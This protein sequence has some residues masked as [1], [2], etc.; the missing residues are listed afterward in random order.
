MNAYNAA[1]FTRFAGNLK[2]EDGKR[3][4]LKKF[5]KDILR[6]HF[7]Q[8]RELVV[9]IPKKNG[10][11][12]LLAALALFHLT[13]RDRA[14]VIIVAASRDQ[15]KV[16]F[17]Q[18]VML[19]ESTG[20]RVKGTGFRGSDAPHTWNLFGLQ[21]DIRKGYREIRANDGRIKV[22]S[23][24]ADT[25]DGQIPTLALVDEL[26]RHRDGQL[27]D[28]LMRG[29]GPRQGRMVT[30]S[31]AGSTEESALGKL[32]QKAH[33]LRSRKITARHKRYAKGE[34]VLHELALEAS[35]DPNDLKTVK[36]V[37]PLQPMSELRRMQDSASNTIGQW[38]RFTC[39]IWTAGD[40]PEILPQDWDRLRADIGVVEPGDR[41]VLAPSAGG[42]AVVGIA[43]MRPDG[44]VAVKAEHLDAPQGRSILAL[45]ENK[46]IELC[47]VYDVEIVLGPRYGLTRAMELV[48][49]RGAPVEEHPYST[50]RQIEATA[51]FDRYLRSGDI[52]H[53]GDV[54]TRAHVLAAIKKVGM[55]GEHYMASDQT[56]AIVA[57]SQAVHAATAL[58]D[59]PLRM[60][61]SVGRRMRLDPAPDVP[62]RRSA[63]ST[64][65]DGGPGSVLPVRP[66]QPP[67]GDARGHDDGRHHRPAYLTPRGAPGARR[68]A[69]SQPHLHAGWPARPHARTRTGRS[70][71]DRTRR[72]PC[73]TRSTPISPTW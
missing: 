27:Y 63:P 14:E 1:A 64:D 38:L 59:E 2:I 7:G 35:D 33:T 39:G 72:R 10:K 6:D 71:P 19:V 36:M 31:T 17:D 57:I 73:S 24:D 60:L 65:G 45:L 67:A 5:Q 11:T 54:L 56:R 53:D 44:K 22:L 26:H 29:I 30:I 15:A 48:E 41:V 16:M 62:L 23:A 9:V 34:F 50:P 20:E 51:T 49:D 55:M 52:I 25:A 8:A 21:L 37:N 28:V 40:E 46:I 12:T 68:A 3:L 13:T 42:N 66:G 47:D 32:R 18:A 69:R 61:A 58:P 43:A 70:S 4:K